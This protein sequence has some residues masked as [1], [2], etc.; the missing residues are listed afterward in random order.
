MLTSFLQLYVKGE[1]F[2]ANSVALNILIQKVSGRQQN[3]LISLF[4]IEQTNETCTSLSIQ[5]FLILN[6]F[7]T[8]PQIAKTCRENR[9]CHQAVIHV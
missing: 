8:F 3:A 7:S 5:L 6:F 4:I 1:M 2:H 9:L